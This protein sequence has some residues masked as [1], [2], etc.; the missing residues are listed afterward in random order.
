MLTTTKEDRAKSQAKAQ[1]ESICELVKWL[2]H[3]RDCDD[4]DC[5]QGAG[6]N[7][8]CGNRDEYHNEDRACQAIQEDPLSIEVRS[9]WE[10]FVPD[11]TNL[12]P[13]EYNILLCTGGPAVRILGDLNEDGSPGTAN[14]EYQDWFVAWEQYPLELDD[15]EKLIEYARQFYFGA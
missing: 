1:L 5:Q 15:E 8:Y 6:G 7:D 12:K 9:G 14:L 11:A 13:A 3:V 2:E 4:P 10:A